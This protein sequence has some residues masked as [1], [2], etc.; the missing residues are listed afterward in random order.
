M[1]KKSNKR[2][3]KIILTIVTFYLAPDWSSGDWHCGAAVSAQD[4]L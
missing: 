2:K 4:R 1:E 3:K